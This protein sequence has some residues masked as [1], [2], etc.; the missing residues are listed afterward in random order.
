MEDNPLVQADKPMYD[1]Y[2][3]NR[4]FNTEMHPKDADGMTNGVDLI[5]LILWAV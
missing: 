3:T 2:V 4:G 5:R 1:F